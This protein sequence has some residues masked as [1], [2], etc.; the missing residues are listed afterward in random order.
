MK[1]SAPDSFSTPEKEA[2]RIL[3]GILFTAIVII[4]CF[5]YESSGTTRSEIDIRCSKFR[6]YPNGVC[7][8]HSESDREYGLDVHYN[9]SGIQKIFRTAKGT[10]SGKVRRTLNGFYH[11]NIGEYQYSGFSYSDKQPDWTAEDFG[12]IK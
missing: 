2:L 4:S 7:H 11:I 9:R 8:L 5:I 10:P 3:G 12:F 1:Q 6:P